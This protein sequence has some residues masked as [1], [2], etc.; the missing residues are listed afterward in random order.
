LQDTS[1]EFSEVDDKRIEKLLEM[2][3]RMHNMGFK[4]KVIEEYLENNSFPIKGKLFDPNAVTKK[5][6]DMMPSR[7]RKDGESNDKIGTGEEGTTRED[8][9]VSKAFKGATFNIYEVQ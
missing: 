5:S 2:A 8:Q 4:T 7:S 3:E 9:L 6:E 1:F